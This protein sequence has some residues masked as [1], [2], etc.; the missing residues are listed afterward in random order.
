MMVTS[1]NTPLS[2]IS[3]DTNTGSPTRRNPAVGGEPGVI[4][5]PANRLTTTK[6]TTGNTIDPIA[7]SGSRRKILISS[8]VSF[9]SPRIIAGSPSIADRMAGQFQKDVLQVG[10]HGGKVGDPDPVL[11][12]TVDH[13]GHEV[14]APPLKSEMGVVARHVLDLRNRPQAF[15]GE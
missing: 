4:R 8:Q 2:A 14:V 12:E 1:D 7:P 11:G 5:P 3:T 6:T 9:Q 10:Q 13:L 15:L